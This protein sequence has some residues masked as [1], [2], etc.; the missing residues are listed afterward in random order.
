[1]QV[2]NVNNGTVLLGYL[3][4]RIGVDIEFK[5]SVTKILQGELP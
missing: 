2:L 3:L 4:H 1:M 5:I